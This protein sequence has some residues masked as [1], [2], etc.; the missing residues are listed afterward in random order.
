MTSRDPNNRAVIEV[1]HVAGHQMRDLDARRFA[2]A[3]HGD[4]VADLRMQCRS[5]PLGPGQ[6]APASGLGVGR[7][8]RVSVLR[9]T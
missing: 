9:S 7:A 1:R 2:V 4:E 5:R 3:N 6:V 8:M